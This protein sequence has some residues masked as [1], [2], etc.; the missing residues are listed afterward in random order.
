MASR[1]F[2]QGEAHLLSKNHQPMLMVFELQIAQFVGKVFQSVPLN[3]P[4][5]TISANLVYH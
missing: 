5:I 4:M 3:V 2:P 1:W